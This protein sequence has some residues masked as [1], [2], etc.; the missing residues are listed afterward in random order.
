LHSWVVVVA[1]VVVVMVVAVVVVV[2]VVVEVVVGQLLQNTG[3][4]FIN[5]GPIT[6]FTQKS[7]FSSKSQSSGSATPLQF[8]VVVTVVVDRVDVVVTVVT[9]VVVDVVVGH[10]LQ[11]TGHTLPTSKS[12]YEPG[13]QYCC[14]DGVQMIESIFPSQVSIVVVVAV[15][16]VIDVVEVV[17]TQVP[18]NSG[19]LALMLAPTVS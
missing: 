9:V 19:H 12:A 17:A 10:V 3:Q 11:R 16:V 7:G 4:S 8:G 1:V 15:V 6:G 13:V 18:Q 5:C 2:R 14:N